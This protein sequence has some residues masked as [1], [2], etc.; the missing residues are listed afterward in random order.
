MQAPEKAHL[1]SWIPYLK[2]LNVKSMLATLAEHGIRTHIWLYIVDT[3]SGHK[4]STKK[5]QKK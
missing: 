4:T 5:I 1:L 2:R 3:S